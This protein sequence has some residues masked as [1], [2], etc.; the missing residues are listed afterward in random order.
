MKDCLWILL[1]GDE[2]GSNDETYFFSSGMVFGLN[3][4]QQHSYFVYFSLTLSYV[5]VDTRIWNGRFFFFWTVSIISNAL[6]T[7]EILLN[8][9]RVRACD[10]AA[11]VEET[12]IWSDMPYTVRKHRANGQTRFCFPFKGKPISSF[13]IFFSKV[14]IWLAS[15]P[16]NKR[17]NS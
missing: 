15:Y 9:G 13:R 3:W 11:F 14:Y 12:N 4:K 10:S 2:N 8:S 5:L 16:K 7:R 17:S 6:R 1:V